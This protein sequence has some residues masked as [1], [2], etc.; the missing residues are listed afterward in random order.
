MIDQSK[1]LSRSPVQFITRF[2]QVHNYVV[3]FTS[4]DKLHEFGAEKPIS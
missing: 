3:P 4:H 1:I 2:V